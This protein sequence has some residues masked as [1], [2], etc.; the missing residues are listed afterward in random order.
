MFLKRTRSGAYR[1]VQL[2]E[3]YR[4]GGRTRQRVLATLGRE[5]QL[6]REQL[7]RLARQLMGVAEGRAEVDPSDVEVEASREVGRLVVLDQLWQ[8]LELDRIL[9]D[10]LRGRRF[11]FDAAMVIKAIVF[12]RV[13]EPS[14]ERAL[15]RE[16]LA[17]VRWPGFESIRLH[18]TYRALAALAD[19]QLGL[20][21]ALTQVLTQ[22][23]FADVTLTLFDTTSLHFEGRGPRSLAAYGY[24][25]TRPDLVQVRLGL[26]TS[27]EGLPLSHWVFPGHQTDLESFA[28]ASRH[29]RSQLPVGD[30]TVVA[31]R[32]MVREENLQ[33]LEQAKIPYIVGVRL[34]WN[35]ARQA[36]ATAGRYRKVRPN[37]FVK[38][39]HREE[40][41]R[42][43]VCYNPD[44]AAEDRRQREAMVARLE[45]ALAEGPS[46]WKQFLKGPARRYLV[47]QGVRPELDRARIRDDARYDGKWV[48]WTTTR[49]SPEEV[50][51]AYKGL[52]EVEECFRTLKTPLEIQPVYHWSEP[53]VRG[54]ITSAVLALLLARLIEQRLE[55]AGMPQRARTA[56]A[57]LSDLDEVELAIG[58]HRLYRIRR[59]TDEQQQLLRALRV[60]LPP[61]VRVA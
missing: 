59:L 14:S 35:A 56:L 39:V 44:A 22:K 31:D 33:A 11:G 18:H 10:E 29:F 49:Q 36:L 4:D 47:T 17:K 55:A 6:D 26:L 3:A 60:P 41:R 23:L 61:A 32:G 43:L 20:Q 40:G 58:R 8:E 53:G 45:Q 46:A 38:E 15:V 25:P 30:F 19:I 34:R 13:I 7:R 9:G 57:A 48:L 12:G 5:D 24:S 21:R 16:W 50:A 37:L 1:Y 42:V 51:L 2:V 27:R 54:H 52:L 28:E